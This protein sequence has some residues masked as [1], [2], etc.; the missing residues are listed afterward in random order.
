MLVE[1]DEEE[2]EEEL[3]AEKKSLSPPFSTV[4]VAIPLIEEEEPADEDES[5]VEVAE[6]I[7]EFEPEAPEIK[8]STL[9]ELSDKQYD[10][11][12]TV[13]SGEGYSVK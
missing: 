10:A 5:E 9:V 2:E 3:P 4:T 7:G 6:D 8:V 11:E 12:I 13:E 1:E